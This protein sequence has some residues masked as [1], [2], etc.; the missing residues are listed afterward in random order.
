MVLNNQEATIKVGDQI[1]IRTSETTNTSS[2]TPTTGGG[3]TAAIT[4]Q[5]QQRDTGVTLTVKPRINP[6]GLVIMEIDQKVDNIGSS[7]SGNSGNPDIFQRQ[8]KSTVAVQSGETLVLGG[9]ISVINDQSK[10]GIP[11]LH[12]LP[13]IGFLFG[14]TTTRVEWQELVVLIT[15]RVVENMR[16][17]RAVT[18]EFKR[19][20]T[21]IYENLPVNEHEE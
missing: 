9:L 7:S 5:F 14:T 8:I 21:G 20:M 12:N 1:S 11:F 19:K 3:S 16:D 17:A 4:S 13:L 18:L 15:P 10:S 2:A 6:G